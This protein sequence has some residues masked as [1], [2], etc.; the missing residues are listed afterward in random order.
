M[1]NLESAAGRR[2][3]KKEERSRKRK[4]IWSTASGREE[5]GEG[6]KRMK[7]GEERKRGKGGNKQEGKKENGWTHRLAEPFSRGVE[8]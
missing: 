7:T 2:G 1:R 6:G 4:K 3:R 5:R 8:R